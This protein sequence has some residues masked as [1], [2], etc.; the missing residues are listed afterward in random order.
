M[1]A[2][3]RKSLD[4]WRAAGLL[5]DE[6]VTAIERFEVEQ[7]AAK[8]PQIPAIV[9][10]LI[11]LGVSAVLGSLMALLSNA[12]EDIGTPVRALILA[13]LAIAAGAAGGMLRGEGNNPLTRASTILWVVSVGLAWAAGAVALNDIDSLNEGVTIMLAGAP[14]TL[15]AL[16]YYAAERR[17][18]L[19]GAVVASILAEAFAIQDAV[20]T[21]ESA[22]SS[23]VL[24][25]VLG[26][27]C[28]LVLRT[29]AIRPVW[30]GEGVASFCVALGFFIPSVEDG[31]TWAE[32]AGLAVAAG[33]L[34]LSIRQKSGALLVVGSVALFGFVTEIIFKHLAD[35]LGA[36]LAL[37]LTGMALIGIAIMMIRLRKQTH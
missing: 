25:A 30:L 17:A 37:L 11:Y 33:I 26:L 15:L 2:D 28:W 9:E 23:G 4:S 8:G 12:W 27:V 36:P 35:S 18:L 21:R 1:I 32:I 20:L 16:A 3:Y 10:V 14:A 5:T 13:A 19:F 6:Q 7:A 31:G 29:G 22:T 34:W 24:L